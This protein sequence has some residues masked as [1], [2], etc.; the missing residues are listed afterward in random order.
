M[1]VVDDHDPQAKKVA[2]DHL[3]SE[4]TFDS[5]DKINACT[6][7]AISAHQTSLNK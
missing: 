6:A 5:I 2:I 1:V 7:T 3:R 4:I